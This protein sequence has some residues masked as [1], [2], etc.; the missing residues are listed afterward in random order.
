[1]SFSSGLVRDGA[2]RVQPTL[3]SPIFQSAS[4]ATGFT[5]YGDAIQRASF[6]SSVSGKSPDWHVLLGQ[7][8]V[9]DSEAIAVP[10][11]QG[12]GY[13]GSQSGLPIGLVNDKWLV[14]QEDNL[15]NS[16]H[17][18][19]HTLVI[20]LTDDAFTFTEQGCCIYGEHGVTGAT[21]ING[22][23]TNT[24]IFA[25]Y[26]D[27]RVWPDTAPSVESAFNLNESDVNGLSHEVAEWIADPLIVNVVPS[28]QIATGAA[29]QY[30]CTKFLEVGD[31]LVGTSFIKKMPN[32]VT[33][34]LQDEAFFSW[35]ARSRISTGFMNRYTY[36]G[37]FPTFSPAC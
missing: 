36:L 7:P 23:R 11:N 2:D 10:S 1:L 27:P 16:L 13:V 33:Y 26:T 18:D 12:S 15:L 19:P 6:W 8:S 35:F 32:G 22:N 14:N 17:I 20:F 37:A 28:W 34:S 5:Q 24:W 3:Q 4:F 9:L 25:A 30:G 21:S 31:P 29:S